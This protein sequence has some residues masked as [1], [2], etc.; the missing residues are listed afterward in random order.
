[1]QE[2]TIRVAPDAAAVYLAATEQDRRKLDA[3]LSLRLSQANL[4]TRPL[5]DVIRD[6]SGEAQAKGLT[7]ELLRE[8]LDDKP[9]D[10]SLRVAAK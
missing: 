8:V 9:C 2:I 10:I 1:M 3:M 5:R 6:A 7:P 4:Q